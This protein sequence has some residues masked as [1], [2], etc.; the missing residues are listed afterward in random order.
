MRNAEDGVPYG[1]CRDLFLN[2]LVGANCVRP[3][4]S[5]IFT[6]ENTVL[7]YGVT[8]RF[9]NGLNVYS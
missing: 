8:F 9:Y 3:L 2:I 5:I 4:F 1:F 7:P 6:R